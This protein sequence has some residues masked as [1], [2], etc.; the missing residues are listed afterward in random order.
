MCQ[1][2]RNA[3]ALPTPIP[4]KG[5]RNSSTME[6]SPATADPEPFLVHYND[7]RWSALQ[8]AGNCLPFCLLLIWLIAFV[9]VPGVPLA[10]PVRFFALWGTAAG[11]LGTLL[12]A[13]SLA[14]L[15]RRKWPW[16]VIDRQGI[17]RDTMLIA[18]D[19]VDS[20]F[21]PQRRADDAPR[22]IHLIVVVQ[23]RAWTMGSVN[24]VGKTPEAWHERL[25]T[26]LAA[27]WPG[28]RWFDD[29]ASFGHRQ[30][31]VAALYKSIPWK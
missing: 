8:T 21:I 30:R 16:V 29:R 26:F 27:E 15:F 31:E 6:N 18:W 23:D 3:M 9:I 24:L 10:G 13:V 11:V 17:A 14:V 2:D 19:R 7:G 28:I 20:I 12:L 22:E 1:V 4:G 5:R 25:R